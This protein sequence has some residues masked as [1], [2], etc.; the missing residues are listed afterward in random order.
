MA[1]AIALAEEGFFLPDAEA[2]RIASVATQ[3][4]EFEGSRH[5]F[6]KPDGS[7]FLAGERFRQP[8][9]A[10]T[11]RAVATRGPVAFYRGDIARSIDADMA[12]RG[13]FVRFEDLAGYAAEQAL[14]VRGNYRGYDLAGTYL[15]ASGATTIQILQILDQLDLSAYAGTSR[16]AAVVAQALLLGFADR[17]SVMEPPSRKAAWLVSRSLALERARAVRVAPADSQSPRN[18][19]LHEGASPAFAEEPEHTTHL[20]VVDRD[21]MVVALTQSVGP[22]MG[23]KVAAPGLGFVYAATMGYLGD[24]VPGERPFSSQSPLVVLRGGRPV[25]VLGAAGAR[26]IISAIVET[27]SRAIDQ[28]LPFEQAM[29]SPRFHVTPGFVDLEDRADA[30]W[31]RSDS[32]EIRRFGF[33]PRFRSDAP[34]FGRING[35]SW[36]VAERDW[37]GVADSRWQGAASGPSAIRP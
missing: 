26:R 14:V 15:P 20:S 5:Y 33:E 6:L 18:P 13:G 30:A 1:P 9:L 8:D 21:G 35:I 31:T 16:W 4:R 27:L 12:R 34:Y 10:R 24:V 25:Y 37:V 32:T 29:A 36:D 7:L 23:S 3:L 17:D 11:L 28:R 22:L 19:L 2:A